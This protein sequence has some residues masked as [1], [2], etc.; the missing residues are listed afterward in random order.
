MAIDFPNRSRSY[1]GK[2]H[3]V[4]FWGHDSAR[5]V[6]FLVAEEALARVD[7]TTPRTEDEFLIAFDANRD[8]IF[9]AARKAYAPRG[10]G[11]HASWASDF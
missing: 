11:F 7:Q 9:K 2:R 8:R 4:R 10:T 5:E 1:V 3:S 6:S